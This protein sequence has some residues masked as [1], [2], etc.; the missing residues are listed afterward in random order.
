MVS[1]MYHHA[2]R[3]R[4]VLAGETEA[5]RNRRGGGSLDLNRN[6]AVA[7]L[8]HEVDF[9]SCRATIKRGLEARDRRQYLFD[10]E[11]FPA[12]S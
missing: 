5:L 10:Y 6:T 8:K 11:P 12:S 3:G 9:G 7:P 1:S 2:V 4:Y